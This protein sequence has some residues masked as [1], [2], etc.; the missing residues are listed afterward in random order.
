MLT[1]E[2]GRFVYSSV[3]NLAI[4]WASVDRLCAGL[5][6]PDWELA[7]GCPGWTVKDHLSHLVDYEDGRSAGPPRITILASCCTCVMTWAGSTR[8]AWTR[9]AAGREQG[10][11]RVP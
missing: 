2:E 6:D 10:A 7:T 5:P 11:R 1:W 3:E 4:V 8:S 9:A